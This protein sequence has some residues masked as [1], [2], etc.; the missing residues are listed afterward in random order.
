MV[1]RIT[2]DATFLD[3]LPA[4]D[5]DPLVPPGEFLGKRA[6]DVLPAEIAGEVERKINLALRTDELQ[7]LEYDL[8]TEKGLKSFEARIAPIGGNEVL[9]IVRDV[10][11]RRRAQDDLE[12]L[13]DALEARVE[14]TV[15]SSTAYGLSFRELTVLY[16]A[17]EGRSDK[18]IAS[19]L[20]ISHRTVQTHITHILQKMDASNR[21]E[22]SARAQREGLIG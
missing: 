22:A 17:A 13:R 7:E 15:S 20:G 21:A 3:F 11:A 5:L 19:I 12:R 1:F 10:T 16:L 4:S 9:A 8:A 6:A 18:E 14:Q 2:A